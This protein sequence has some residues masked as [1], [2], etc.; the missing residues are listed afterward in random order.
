MSAPGL[1]DGLSER[2][3]LAAFHRGEGDDARGLEQQRA[4]AALVGS[5]L[6]RAD[7]RFPAL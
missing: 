1:S 3:R 4:A 2:A 7:V 6:D 5:R